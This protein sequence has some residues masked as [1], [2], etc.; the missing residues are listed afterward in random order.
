MLEE[1]RVWKMRRTFPYRE[2]SLF[3]VDFTLNSLCATKSFGCAVEAVEAFV[4]ASPKNERE[5][6][7]VD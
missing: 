3:G 4:A 6:S 1:M 2:R 5:N 7:N